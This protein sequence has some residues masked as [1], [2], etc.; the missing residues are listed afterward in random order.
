M[1]IEKNVLFVQ[2]C[3]IKIQKLVH[4]HVPINYSDRVQKMATGMEIT[5]NLYV[6]RNMVKNV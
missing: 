6:F 5:T 3:I 1:Q 2:P 4:M